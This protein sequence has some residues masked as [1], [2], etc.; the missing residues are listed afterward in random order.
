MS[1][2]GDLFGLLP[3]LRQN[4][5][6]ASLV[7]VLL[8]IVF[9]A[10]AISGVQTIIHFVSSFKDSDVSIDI[11]SVL[12]KRSSAQESAEISLVLHW[13]NNEDYS[14]TV[15]PL[16]IYM[17]TLDVGQSIRG[18]IFSA[19]AHSSG[20][21]TVNFMSDTLA[22]LLSRITPIK[23]LGCQIDYQMGASTKVRS[24]RVKSEN[25]RKYIYFLVPTDTVTWSHSIEETIATFDM[26]QVAISKQNP[27]TL[28]V[29][30]H[31]Q[32]MILYPAERFNLAVDRDGDAQVDA[33]VPAKGKSQGEQIDSGQIIEIILDEKRFQEREA[34]FMIGFSGYENWQDSIMFHYLDNPDNRQLYDMFREE[35]DREM[36]FCRDF[37]HI[38]Y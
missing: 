18:R 12:I 33:I 4:K 27:G 7:A 38:K 1:E 16:R 10:A 14:S 11:D 22:R 13:Q 37:I 35:T 3:R 23:E 20:F 31:V 32:N 28:P 29:L 6:V 36:L 15:S 21:D 19:E 8:L 2:I 9:L 25:V 24:S 34:G 30:S 5:M 26:M 17:N